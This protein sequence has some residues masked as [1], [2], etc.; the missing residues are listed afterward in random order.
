MKRRR[1]KCIVAVICLALLLLA[2][3][4][5]GVAPA[6]RATPT[7]T[8]TPRGLIFA[9][10]DVPPGAGEIEMRVADMLKLGGE[11]CVNYFPFVVNQDTD[12]LTITGEGVVACHFQSEPSEGGIWHAVMDYT[13]TV[14]GEIIPGAG[15][16]GAAL[17]RA[18]LTFDGTL[19]QYLTDY[20]SGAIVPF[21]VDNPAVIRDSGPMSLD[22][23]Y[24]DGATQTVLRNNPYAQEP[25]SS[26]YKWEFILHLR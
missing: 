21:T 19:S 7:P 9:G 20:P 15:T 25:T 3:G 6:G 12:P 26:E 1:Q 18:V 14:T 13:V 8:P 17:L 16:G 11:D 22:F 2:C 23:D 5:S 24:V 10:G 4:P